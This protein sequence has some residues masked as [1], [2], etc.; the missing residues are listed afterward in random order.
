MRFL[1][2]LGAPT[3]EAVAASAV[4]GVA[5]TVVEIVLI[6]VLLAFV[7]V[8]I[9]T[10]ELE[11]GAPS[12]GLLLAIGIALVVGAA[13]V[14]GVPKLRARIV[15]QLTTAFGSLWAVARDRG[16]R[17][18]LFGGTILTEVVFALTL[19][20]ACHAYGVDLTLGQLL[21]VNMG[22]S[23]LAG[24]LPVPGGIGA[25]EAA[26]TAGLVAVGVDESTAFAIALTHRLCTYYL[27]PILGYFSLKWLQRR[28]YL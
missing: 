10:N 21:L 12:G 9:D 25:A 5:E 8:Q 22:A 3:G 7:D 6:L 11:I 23:A 24:L 15:P 2:R 19:G 16:K 27:P 18:E 20:A 13:V 26:I 1:Q 14:F 17:L 4:D 28:A